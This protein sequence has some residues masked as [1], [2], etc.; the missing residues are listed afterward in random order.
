MT[1]PISSYLMKKAFQ[2]KDQMS[3]YFAPSPSLLENLLLLFWKT[4]LNGK[5][6]L[7]AISQDST[8]AL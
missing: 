6:Y 2:E 4:S 3:V 1:L 7:A 8:V 5:G